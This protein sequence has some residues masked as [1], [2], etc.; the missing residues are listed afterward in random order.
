MDRKIFKELTI[1]NIFI[2]LL[3]VP[4]LTK[5]IHIDDPAFLN[6]AKQIQKDPLRPYSFEHEWGTGRERGVDLLDTPLIPYYLALISFIFGKSE[7]VLHIAFIAFNHI[8]GISFYFISRKFVQW[9]LLATLILVSTP[10]FLVNSQNL[11]LDIPMLSLFLLAIALFIYGVD[12]KKH[13]LLFFGSIIAGFAY[14][15]KPHAI[16]IIP[17]L[18]FYCLLKKRL[19]YMSYMSI[20]ILFIILFAIHNYFFED[21]VII[22]KYTSFLLGAKQSSFNVL[23]AY[24]FS[25]LS[26]IG[27]ATIFPLF[28][29]YPFLLRK[30][31]LIFF[32][33]S[34]FITGMVSFFLYNLSS[35]FISGRYT[36]LQI[37]LFL[38]FTS[39]SIFFIILLIAENYKNI[40]LG[41]STKT[42]YNINAFFIFAWFI[43]LFIFNSSISGGAVRYNVLLLPPLILSY[44]LL[45]KRYS[46]KISI[47]PYR[48][49]LLILLFTVSLGVIV[50]YAD[51]DYAGSYRDFAINY[52][53][54]YQTENNT[55]WFLGGHGFQYYMEQQGYRILLKE[56]NSPKKGDFIIKAQIPS[57]RTMTNELI[58]RITL[59]EIVSYIG[60]IPIRIQNPEAHAGFY[61]YGG[62][63]LPYSISNVPLENFEIYAVNVDVEK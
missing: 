41:L 23:V 32:S 61:T 31:N 59:I 6:M 56:D 51:Y 63:F 21:V 20:P 43:G 37:L 40:K 53:P 54:Q 44:L 58:E 29:I 60:K 42:D 9:P 46:Q 8:A 52:P 4:F 3:M 17:L 49:L 5:P 10:T 39:S 24:L 27:G 47:N 62:G 1:L 14:L 18:I 25:N 11:M 33:I 55:I 45:L 19:K 16:I 2:L 7:V 15:A 12:Q 57:P 38:I 36:S 48:L 22:A 26:Y 50:A 30:K 34:I 13:R 35:N 28:L